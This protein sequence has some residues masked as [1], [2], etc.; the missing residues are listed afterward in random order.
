[1]LNTVCPGMLVHDADIL[2]TTAK[3][4]IKMERT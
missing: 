2:K 4:A 3:P 1:M